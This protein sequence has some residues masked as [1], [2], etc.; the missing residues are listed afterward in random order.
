M[1]LYI[2]CWCYIFYCE[3]LLSKKITFSYD[4]WHSRYCMYMFEFV[5]FSFHFLTFT[6]ILIDFASFTYPI[7]LCLLF[8]LFCT[9][10][11]LVA[12]YFFC[13]S[14]V[15]VGYVLMFLNL[16]ICPVNDEWERGYELIFYFYLKKNVTEKKLK[17]RF[18]KN[19][20]FALFS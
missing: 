17:R 18:I 4:N 8:F 7:F 3:K 5:N 1:S 12:C 9:N 19:F 15:R 13:N 2:A 11:Q 6:S 20:S 16:C 14:S 10:K